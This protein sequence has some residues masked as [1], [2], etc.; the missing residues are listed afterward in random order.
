MPAKTVAAAFLT[1]DQ[2][3]LR[4]HYRRHIFKAHRRFENGNFEQFPQTINHA[5]ARNCP[6]QSAALTFNLK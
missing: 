4:Y 2:R 6:D 5:G 1:A 3:I